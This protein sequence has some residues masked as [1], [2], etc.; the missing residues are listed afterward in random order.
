MRYNGS[1]IGPINDITKDSAGGIRPVSSY[2]SAVIWPGGTTW[3]PADK[4]S[5]I[6]LSNYNRTQRNIT[7]AWHSARAYASASSGKRYYEMQ[8]DEG[9]TNS[10]CI[11]GVGKAAATVTFY[12]GSDA[13]GWAWQILGTTALIWNNGSSASYGAAVT[14]GNGA[15]G[16]IVGVLLDLDAGTLVFTKNGA[17][18]G[19]AYSSLSGTFYPYAGVYSSTHQTTTRFHPREWKYNP[20]AGY[21]PWR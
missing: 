12:P 10:Y 8:F 21:E 13:N 16:D 2:A 18:Q 17:S 11:L 5:N 20:G 9:N 19:T 4:G 7:T 14:G 15:N 3:N 6:Q 1:I